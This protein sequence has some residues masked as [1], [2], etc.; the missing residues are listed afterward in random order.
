M[1]DGTVTWVDSSTGEARISR[2]RRQ[3][4]AR[5]ADVDP[6]ARHVGARVHF[7]VRREDGV[8]IASDVRLRSGARTSRHHRGVGT[9]VGARR[10]D[11][12][13]PA[14]FAFPH[15]EFGLALAGHPLQVAGMWGRC[16]AAGEI[17][18]ALSLYAPDALVYLDGDALRGRRHIQARLEALGVLGRGWLPSVRGEDGTVLLRWE[19][20]DPS[21]PVVDARCQVEHGA[22]TAQWIGAP[23]RLTRS[24]VTA[25]EVTVPLSVV[26]RGDVPEDAVAYA[27]DRIAHVTA[28]VSSPILTGRITLAMSADPARVRPAEAKVSLDLDG[29][30]V[31]AHVASHGMREAVDLLQ[32]R[33]LDKVEHESQHR[34]ALRRHRP[35]A[36]DAGEWRRGSIP[37]PRPD[38][39][40]RAVEDRRL[41]R[42]KAIA[43]GEETLDEAI[44]DLDQLDHEFH[45]Y[46]DLDAG[47]DA[48]VQRL[49]DG[50]Y[51]VAYVH[52]PP[53]GPVPGVEV[54]PVP[55][56]TLELDGALERLNAGGEPFVVFASPVTGRGNV[57]YRR[58]DGHYGLITLEG[59]PTG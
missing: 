39:F 28:H 43:A 21:E 54:E 32:R 45:L 3:Y 16:V 56:P 58:Y 48:V 12:K 8:E 20:P 40:D 50:G 36:P 34:E 26:V 23:D 2:K 42:H 57:A 10:P 9:L 6:P 24:T 41:V 14:P 19:P 55:A 33:L 27:L 47:D 4:I 5:P 1:P 35:G 11:T 29:H 46:R 22:I 53:A 15:P 31:R 13:G 59:A 38:F 18:R 30:V 51:R 49:P 7:D 25:G 52:G 37:T 17:D 44:F